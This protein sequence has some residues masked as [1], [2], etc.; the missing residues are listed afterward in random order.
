MFSIPKLMKAEDYPDNTTHTGISVRDDVKQEYFT[1]TP[2][3]QQIADTLFCAWA[4]S[5]NG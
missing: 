1:M 2:K 4:R 3:R 5:P